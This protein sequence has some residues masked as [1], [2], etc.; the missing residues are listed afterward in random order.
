M[1]ERRDEL[2][3]TAYKAPEG[4]L[5]ELIATVQA[6]ILDVDRVGRGDNY[7]DLGGTSLQAMRICARVERETGYK[8]MPA[9]LF[10]SAVL[11]DFAS[12]ISKEERLGS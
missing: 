6:E 4:D 9:W 3:G 5:E 8:V 2:T 11:S 10:E 12:R 1:S 7:Y